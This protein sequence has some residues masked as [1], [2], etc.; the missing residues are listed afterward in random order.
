MYAPNVA[1]SGALGSTGDPILYPNAASLAVI[2][3]S[4][5]HPGGANHLFA[6]GSV[7]FIKNTISSWVR[8]TPTTGLPTELT[9]TT[10]FTGPRR[11]RPA[12]TPILGNLP[13]YQALS[14]RAG[15]EVISA[16]AY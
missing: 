10:T 1:F 13:V 11:H 4:S 14:T 8:P 16:D 12:P 2:S 9:S 3:A 6:D 5:N 15:G 7:K